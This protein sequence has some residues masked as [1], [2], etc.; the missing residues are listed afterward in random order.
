MN[1]NDRLVFEK[2]ILEFP[3]NC[4]IY[5]SEEDFDAVAN[6]KNTDNTLSEVINFNGRRIVRGLNNIQHDVH[7]RA[8]VANLEDRINKL[9]RDVDEELNDWKVRHLDKAEETGISPD[10]PRGAKL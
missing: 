3:E 8:S 4:I 6:Q 1:Y 9:E 7:T 5:L 2:K 10:S